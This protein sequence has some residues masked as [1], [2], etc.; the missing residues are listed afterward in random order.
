MLVSC[1]ALWES[2]GTA[3]RAYGVR[4][5]NSGTYRVMWDTEG[6][7]FTVTEWKI[8]KMR[9]LPGYM[10]REMRAGQLWVI[11]GK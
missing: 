7:K 3:R 6:I 9:A 4:V 5:P 1:C 10:M 2:R 8:E 11:R